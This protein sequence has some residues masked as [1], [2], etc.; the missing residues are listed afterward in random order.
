MTAMSRIQKAIAA[1]GLDVEGVDEATL[2]GTFAML[3]GWMAE[4]KNVRVSILPKLKEQ[5]QSLIDA[6]ERKAT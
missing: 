3:G 4:E 6:M 2:A 5:G 1:S